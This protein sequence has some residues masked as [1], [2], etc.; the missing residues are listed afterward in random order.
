MGNTVSSIASGALNSLSVAQAVSANNLANVNTPGFKASS[1]RTEDVAGGGVTSTPVR[2]E[3]P[4]EI[5]RE[6][7]NLLVNSNLYKANVKTL[8]ADEEMTRT[9]LSMKA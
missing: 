2:G 3:D 4:V 5:S 7:A 9:L 6:A 1:V 8:Q